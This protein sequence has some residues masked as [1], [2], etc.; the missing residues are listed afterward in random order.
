VRSLFRDAYLKIDRANKH[1]ADFQ[2]TVIAQ[3]DPYTTTIEHH[4]DIGAQSLIHEFPDL[5]RLCV[6]CLSSQGT[7]FTTSTALWISR[8][9]AQFGS[10]YLIKSPISTKFPVRE[11][12]EN[13]EGVLHGIEVDTRCK[14]LFDCIVSEIQPYKG[15]NNS[16]IW[17]LHDL[18]ISD[19][20]L[21]ILGLDSIGQ[22][23]GFTVRDKN[24]EIHRGTT[25]PAN[26]MH[27]RYII[28][29]GS[30]VQIEDKGKLSVAIILQEA[31]IFQSVPI[32]G[33]L[34]DF[35]NYITYAVK[36]LENI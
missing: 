24:G 3:Q 32:P 36:L 21:L 12:V 29:L 13:L 16:V 18:D 4:P 23:R 15:G 2:L 1:I 35:S 28:D 31:G 30:D 34:Q 27:G 19:K 5:R 11:T 10:I 9:T 6:I 26:G 33:L 22:I 14:R 7:P 8:G 20:H 17:T 25:W